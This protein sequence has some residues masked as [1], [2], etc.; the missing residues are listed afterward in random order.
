MEEAPPVSE[1]P[2]PQVRIR[3]P[4]SQFAVSRT[5]R[6]PKR[7]R[8]RRKRH[9]SVL[10][11]RCLLPS[12]PVQVKEVKSVFE[13]TPAQSSAE[14]SAARAVLPPVLW[15]LVAVGLTGFRAYELGCDG[16]GRPSLHQE[17]VTFFHRRLISSTNPR[18]LLHFTACPSF[19]LSKSR[20]DMFRLAAIQDRLS[21]TLHVGAH[22]NLR[23]T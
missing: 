6:R 4:S 12:P 20:V 14:F 17:L 23:P 10:A 19:G 2:A 22:I 15:E 7:K 9:S 13:S 8:K 11:C 5:A 3:L 21:S 16:S 18:P 1:T